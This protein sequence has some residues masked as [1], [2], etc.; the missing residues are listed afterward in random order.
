[1]NL[2]EAI[3]RLEEDRQLCK[4]PYFPDPEAEK[5]YEAL[6]MA[7]ACMKVVQD[8]SKESERQEAKIKA[9]EAENKELVNIILATHKSSGKRPKNEPQRA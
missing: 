7:L 6:G 3:E 8:M 2:K 5:S 9:L 4:N 1:M